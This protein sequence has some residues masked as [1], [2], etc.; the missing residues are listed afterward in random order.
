MSLLCDSSPRYGCGM[1]SGAISLATG[2]ATPAD[3]YTTS[4]G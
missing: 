4:S 3:S 2:T 1:S